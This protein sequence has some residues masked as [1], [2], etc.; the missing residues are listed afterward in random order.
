MGEELMLTFNV[1]SRNYTGLLQ[2]LSYA[3]TAPIP[4]LWA[5]RL[6]VLRQAG[7]CAAPVFGVSYLR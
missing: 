7:I 6:A 1:A 4:F 2:P 5:E 3:R